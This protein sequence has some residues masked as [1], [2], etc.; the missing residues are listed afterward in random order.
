MDRRQRMALLGIAAAIAVVVVVIALVSGGGDDEGEKSTTPTTAAQTSPDTQPGTTATTPPEPPKPEPEKIRVK[1][2][3]P[4]G[5]VTKIELE[6]GDKAMID[7]TADEADEAHL[8]G[9]DIEKEVGPGKT[10]KFRFEADL[11]G[12]Y[13]MELHHHGTQL[14]RITVKP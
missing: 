8:H 7:V 10:A 11:E 4:V 1:G 13:E 14:A 12:I 9:Y 6:K 3:E 2:G 5:G